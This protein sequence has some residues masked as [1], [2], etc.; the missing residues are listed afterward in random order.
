MVFLQSMLS[1]KSVLLANQP[2]PTSSKIIAQHAKHDKPRKPKKYKGSWPWVFLV[3]DSI[4]VSIFDIVLN[5]VDINYLR[6][7]MS[8]C[9]MKT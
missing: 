8:K 6:I 3:F 1:T 4:L 5:D 2:I 7:A 9:H